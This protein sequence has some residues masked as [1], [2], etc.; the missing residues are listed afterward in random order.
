MAGIRRRMP[1]APGI[2]EALIAKLSRHVRQQYDPRLVLVPEDQWPSP[3]P[4]YVDHTADLYDDLVAGKAANVP[5]WQL[6]GI[7]D[8]PPGCR[9]VRVEV[10]GTVRPGYERPDMPGEES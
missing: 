7:A 5:T 2:R 10:D 4:P 1:E 9:L 8:V 6:R 3:L